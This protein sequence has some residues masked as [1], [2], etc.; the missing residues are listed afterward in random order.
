MVIESLKKYFGFD[1]FRAGQGE[2]VDRILSGTS[3]AAIFPTGSGKSLCYQ[4]PALHLPNLTL[5]VSPLLALM[6]DQLDFLISRGIAAARIDSSLSRPEEI[7]VMKRVESGEIKILLIAVERF[8]NER[9]RN[10]LNKVPISLMV[11]DEA[12]CISEWGH[13]FRPDYLKLPVYKQD[14][15]IPQVLLL[16][17]TATPA[18]IT[19][20]CDKFRLDRNNVIV[21]GFYRKNLHLSVLPVGEQDKDGM[22]AGMLK[23]SPQLP[24]IVY[25]TLQKTAEHVAE[26]LTASGIEAVA[27]HAGM[28]NEDRE[29]IQNDYMSGRSCCIVAT[30]AF[31]MGIDKR[32]I[33]RVIHYDLPK[34]IENYSQ[35]IGRA[36]RD[37]LDSD[38]TVLANLDN[39]NILEN[40]V[41]GDTPEL[42]GIRIVLNE[43]PRNG[44]NW[45]FKAYTMSMASN[46]RML[47]LKTLLVYLE[48]QGILKPMYSYF[49]DYRY[50][51]NVSNEDIAG[52]FQG[53]RR[54]FLETIFNN[55]KKG[56]KWSV[57]DFGAIM[58][59][60]H[61][62]RGRIVAAL[63]YFDQHGYI[64]LAAKETIEV[65]QVTQ[66]G[67]DI[68]RIATE[69]NDL[70]RHKEQVELERIARMVNFFRGSECLS[71]ALAEYFGEKLS[72]DK[73]GHCSV[74][75][76]GRAEIIRSVQ[77]DSLDSF[78][79]TRL[80]GSFIE[81]LDIPPTADLVTRFL[82]GITVPIIT[83]VKAKQLPGFGSLE[84]YP[85]ADVR[86][87]VNASR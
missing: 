57:V 82:C 53:E 27:Y 14:F 48:M 18:V 10:F 3:A 37:G 30:I 74:C 56:K 23:D 47:T 41:Y 2:V 42:D 86:N 31:G 81:R 32:D 21:T 39:I 33:R 71:Y 62:D 87:W 78:D 16:T 76:Q 44:I 46:I 60:Y 28:Q 13:N 63:E 15:N 54:K 36:G 25:V 59:Q 61:T 4:L 72:R 8:K 66:P 52:K 65:F 34:S 49:A 73:C 29:R 83:Q 40:F 35:E 12:H 43:I 1:E 84:R 38:C 24:T 75:R 70:F 22:L 9:F 11:V 19:D 58:D 80:A 79:F 17:A 55:V 67:F 85:Y 26:F 5:V 68:D 51:N 45:E 69:L 20:M 77:L 64:E 6:Q 7:D 50:A